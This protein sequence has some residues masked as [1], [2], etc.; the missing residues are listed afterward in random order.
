MWSHLSSSSPR[1]PINDV[2]YWTKQHLRAKMMV[3]HLY[4]LMLHLGDTWDDGKV[5]QTWGP[6]VHAQLVLS[7]HIDTAFWKLV[8]Q[9]ENTK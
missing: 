1:R 6:R 8:S 4:R 9:T 3:V 7:S 2:V 5:S